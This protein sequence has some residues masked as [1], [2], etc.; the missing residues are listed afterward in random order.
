MLVVNILFE[1]KK[2]LVVILSVSIIFSYNFVPL[3]AHNFKTNE[4]ASF[5]SLADQLK[6][7]LTAMSS[8]D[9]INPVAITQQA[10][11]ARALLNESVVH[12][13]DERNERV[14]TNLVK[15]LDSLQYVSREELKANVS[16]VFDILSEATSAR[17]EA[18]HLGNAT[19]QA[20][21]VAENVDKIFNEYSAAFNDN[22][23]INSTN[24]T[25]DE[26]FSDTTGSE[27]VKDDTA[28]RR[29]AA[30]TD[31]T[32]EKFNSE[33]KDKSQ[34]HSAAQ[35]ALNGLTRLKT[36]IESKVPP[37]ELLGILHGQ[38]HPNL[39]KSF[40]LQLAGS[41]NSTLN[42]STVHVT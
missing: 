12:E 1:V 2:L 28:H 19:I 4:S 31:I 24:I 25:G 3:H 6:A 7:T 5:I 22:S 42:S 36:S 14:T 23:M 20:I 15:A 37:S 26:P 11:Y 18:D 8:D 10:Q 13:L 34:D 33:L 21:V 38:I 30:L 39:Q 40:G 41:T 29:A 17:I 35:E 16:M 27:S 32:I 9:S